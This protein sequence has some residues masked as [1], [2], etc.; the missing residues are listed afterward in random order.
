MFG[1]SCELNCLDFQHVTCRLFS[2]SISLCFLSSLYRYMY[3]S[4][5]AHRSA[6]V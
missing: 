4:L 3:L 5:F 2:L 6:L 1:A